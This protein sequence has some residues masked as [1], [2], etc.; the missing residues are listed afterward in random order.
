M[1]DKKRYCVSATLLYTIHVDAEDKEEA[2]RLALEK[3]L[4]A[5]HR[6]STETTVAGEDLGHVAGMR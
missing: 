4:D 3:P 5:W 1:S 6:V 2:A